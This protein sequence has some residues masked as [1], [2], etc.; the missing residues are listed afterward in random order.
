[1]PSQPASHPVTPYAQTASVF[2]NSSGCLIGINALAEPTKFSLRGDRIVAATGH[3]VLWPD[4]AARS[5]ALRLLHS[6]PDRVVL[7]EFG[8]Q[9]PVAEHGI[10]V[11]SPSSA[12]NRS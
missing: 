5:G 9:G 1:M 11:A 12:G 8:P 3:E 10:E 7:V 6:T 2:F 4:D